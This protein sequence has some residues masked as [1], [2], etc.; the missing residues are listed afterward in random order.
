MN[1]TLIGTGGVA[2]NLA[3]SLSSQHKITVTGKSIEA[4][5]Y[6]TG[7][8]TLWNAS[9]NYIPDETEVLVIAVQDT[10][11]LSVLQ[12]IDFGSLPNLKV[13]THTSGG[14]GIEVFSSYTQKGAIFYP[15]QTFSKGYTISWKGVPI[16][17]EAFEKETEILL[18]E[19][20]RQIHAEPIYSDSKKRAYIHLGAVFA[21]NF[22]NF[23]LE[24]A[25]QITHKQGLSHNIYYPLL[26]EMLKKAEQASP[27]SVQTGPAKRKDYSTLKSH[28][29]L[30]QNDFP[31]YEP[32]YR[33]LTDYII[34]FTCKPKP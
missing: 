11:I 17:I 18:F 34:E 16:L 7:Y 20:A 8:K 24:V 22:S 25:H 30:L 15:L 12:N 5:T 29:K 13:I 32:L 27:L 2:E 3:V 19:L 31:E 23:L 4:L 21:Q 6:M 9:V 28:I 33:I 1:I 10:N 14:T 26:Q